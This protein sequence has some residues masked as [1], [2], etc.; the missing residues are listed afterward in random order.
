MEPIEQSKPTGPSISEVL[1]KSN[2]SLNTPVVLPEN[3]Q[4]VAIKDRT[5]GSVPVVVNP[6]VLLKDVQAAMMESLI[7]GRLAGGPI[8]TITNSINDATANTILELRPNADP[9]SKDPTEQLVAQQEAA[10]Y[11]AEKQS[12]VNHWMGST[13]P[14]AVGLKKLMAYNDPEMYPFSGQVNPVD[15]L[16]NSKVYRGYWDT[17]VQE[18]GSWF[19][20]GFQ[21]Y[22]SQELD[23]LEAALG[24][25]QANWSPT[26]AGEL[27]KGFLEENPRLNSWLNARGVNLHE[28]AD[29]AQN[30]LGWTYNVNRAILE[31]ANTDTMVAYYKSNGFLSQLYDSLAEQVTRNPNFAVDAGIAAATFAIPGG[32]EVAATALGLPK[33]ASALGGVTRLVG[34]PMTGPVEGMIYSGLRSTIPSIASNALASTAARGAA[35]VADGMILGAAGEY[36]NQKALA[37]FNGLVL[38]NSLDKQDTDWE[39]ITSV[40]FNAGITQLGFYGAMRT[41]GALTGELGQT[42]RAPYGKRYLTWNQIAMGATDSFAR[43]SSGGTVFGSELGQGRGIPVIGNLLDRYLSKFDDRSPVG[44]IIG[45]EDPKGFTGLTPSVT[46]AA[47]FKMEQALKVEANLKEL[48][49]PLYK[50]DPY[51]VDPAVH[52]ATGLTWD[53]INSTVDHLKETYKKDPG[54][55]T[56]DRL[57]AFNNAI[58]VVIQNRQMAKFGID[59]PSIDIKLRDMG[60]PESLDANGILVRDAVIAHE[61]SK[62]K[63]DK[64]VKYIETMIQSPVGQPL[65]KNVVK[66]LM[67][68]K[69][70]VVI[71]PEESTDNWISMEAGA[72]F[73]MEHTVSELILKDNSITA[74]ARNPHT[75]DGS[76]ILSPSDFSEEINKRLVKIQADLE[77]NKSNQIKE[78]V[79]FAHTSMN[80]IDRNWA[81]GVDSA[82]SVLDT[83]DVSILKNNPESLVSSIQTL[84]DTVD[85]ILKVNAK[86][87]AA[88]ITD[89][90][91]AATLLKKFK[92]LLAETIS[93][94]R[95]VL[96]PEVVSAADALLKDLNKNSSTYSAGGVKKSVKRITKGPANRKF[97]SLDTTGWG[98]VVVD[99]DPALGLESAVTGIE[100]L[101]TGGPQDR[102]S[103]VVDRLKNDQQLNGFY[104]LW[105]LN[106]QGGPPRGTYVNLD[107][108]HLSGSKEGDPVNLGEALSPYAS[109]L[110]RGDVWIYRSQN[111]D[112]QLLRKVD[113]KNTAVS[114][115]NRINAEGYYQLNETGLQ[116]NPLPGSITNLKNIPVSRMSANYGSSPLL[117][118]HWANVAWSNSDPVTLKNVV[119]IFGFENEEVDI[120]AAI[121]KLAGMDPTKM[122]PGLRIAES[123]PG[124]SG[125]TE[126][127]G[128][129]VEQ[130]NKGV[131]AVIRANE[132]STLNSW[133]HEIGHYLETVYIN[134]RSPDSYKAALGLSPDDYGDLMEWLGAKKKADGSWS[135]GIAQREKFAKGWVQYIQTLMSGTAKAPKPYLQELFNKLGAH[136]SLL[137]DETHSVELSESAARVYS[138]LADKLSLDEATMAVIPD[139]AKPTAVEAIVSPELKKVVIQDQIESSILSTKENEV[140]TQVSEAAQ[141]AP[142]VKKARL[143]QV[144]PKKSVEPGTVLP[145]KPVIPKADL[146]LEET[147]FDIKPATIDDNTPV[148]ILTEGDVT[149]PQVKPLDVSTKKF[150]ES[151]AA[152]YDKELRKAARGIAKRS[153]NKADSDDLVSDA[154][155][156]LMTEQHDPSFVANPELLKNKLVLHMQNRAIDSVRKGYGHDPTH[157]DYVNQLMVSADDITATLAAKHGLDKDFLFDSLSSKTVK[158]LAA[159]AEDLK[160]KVKR[161][162]KGA[163]VVPLTKEN[164]DVPDKTVALQS[165]DDAAALYRE[166][167][168]L[169]KQ[170]EPALYD[171]TKASI[172][173]GLNTNKFSLKAVWKEVFPDEPYNV[174]KASKLRS[175]VQKYAEELWGKDGNE[176]TS[177][178]QAK[179]PLQEAHS[180]LNTAK[181]RVRQALF[182]YRSQKVGATEETLRTL[183]NNL[184]SAWG[185]YLQAKDYLRSLKGHEVFS[186]SDLEFLNNLLNN[187]AVPYSSD[188]T[189]KL[190]PNVLNGVV[191]N[192][193]PL[194][195]TFL[196]NVEPLK[197]LFDLS[198][199]D[200][201]KWEAMLQARMKSQLGI[202]TTDNNVFSALVEHTPGLKFLASKFRKF[203]GSQTQ[204][205]AIADSVLVPMQYLAKVLNPQVDLRNV[206]LKAGYY[207]PSLDEARGTARAILAA[208]GLSDPEFISGFSRLGP[209]KQQYTQELAWSYVTRRTELPNDLPKEIESHVKKLWGI[210]DFYNRHKLN[211]LVRQHNLVDVDIDTKSRNYGTPHKASPL[212]YADRNG[213]AQAIKNHW[214]KTISASPEF[215]MGIL[216]AM[217]WIKVNRSSAAGEILDYEVPPTSPLHAKLGP[218]GKIPNDF[219]KYVDD[220]GSLLVPKELVDRYRMALEQVTP[221]YTDA[222]RT[223]HNVT[224]IERDATIASR[225][226]LGLTDPMTKDISGSIGSVYNYTQDH[227]LE[228]IFDHDA[229]S[230]DPELSPYFSKSIVHLL[231]QDSSSSL[232]ELHLNDLLSRSLGANLTVEDLLQVISQNIQRNHPGMSNLEFS[233]FT[234][235]LDRIK[236]IIRAEL[237]RLQASPDDVSGPLNFIS[238]NRRSIL[239]SLSGIPTSLNTFV[240]DLPRLVLKTATSR[241]IFT[242][243]VPTIWESLKVLVNRDK[244]LARMAAMDAAHWIHA[245]HNDTSSPR[246]GD[247]EHLGEDATV[248]LKMPVVNSESHLGFLLRKLLNWK[249]ERFLPG[250]S[251]NN[252]KMGTLLHTASTIPGLL[253]RT[254]N[255]ATSAIH[256]YHYGNLIV[257]N[258]D[259]LLK[260]VDMLPDHTELSRPKFNALAVSLGLKPDEVIEMSS[261]GLLNKPHLL[262]IA[263]GIKETGL[264]AGI[265]DVPKL[266]NWALQLKAPEESALATDAIGRM[267]GFIQTTLRNTNRE[268]TLLDLRVSTN[269]V[270]KI[271][272]AYTQFVYS[273]SV[274]SWGQLSRRGTVAASRFLFGQ[275]AAEAAIMFTLDSILTPDNP[276]DK[277]EEMMT[278]PMA[279]TAFALSRAPLWG[280]YSWVVRNALVLGFL[281]RNQIFGIEPPNQKWESLQFPTFLNSPIGTQVDNTGKLLAKTPGLVGKFLSGQPMTP[282]EKSWAIRMLPG[283]RNLALWGLSSGL[284]MN[285]SERNQSRNERRIKAGMNPVVPLVTPG[286][287]P[288]VQPQ[289]SPPEPEPEPKPQDTSL[290]NRIQNKPALG[291]GLLRSLR[292]PG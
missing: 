40:G 224:P 122:A 133:A 247:F 229:I 7:D 238:K 82:T 97:K 103:A 265:P 119:N 292:N 281:L 19:S 51:L 150:V 136:I 28:W 13:D 62:V 155:E 284:F 63:V 99:A 226:L 235:G 159:I 64:T 112:I 240:G 23:Q 253:V 282:S 168:T 95:M 49:D 90:A 33:V 242:K 149:D 56:M 41:F 73:K 46:S 167:I 60:L 241:D 14:N 75:S 283:S 213:F 198:D 280:T 154:Y 93:S 239:T 171:W 152:T 176:V 202:R 214:M 183:R 16:Q 290:V 230:R 254:A 22:A 139:I 186:V 160:T 278:N 24:E 59:A 76:V 127:A 120:A 228:R 96:K 196:N 157:E 134:P 117:T 244:R 187:V 166:L 31:A 275:F 272:N 80:E 111:N 153:G 86:L 145:D 47:N 8:Q 118:D 142:V 88:Q 208:S 291:T 125:I 137:K 79:N 199:I 289:V 100:H 276:G 144:K 285:E 274:Q 190:L 106:S 277:L 218:D 205:G 173:H 35:L 67:G 32:G 94:K 17:F 61:V 146:A 258:M 66:D 128:I 83:T 234:K 175:K 50:V 255:D 6:S 207:M 195:L 107:N 42:L 257:N 210:L 194:G 221:D 18:K 53:D 249:N 188:Y 259:S 129:L 246:M 55:R 74:D 45:W 256:A 161:E 70:R 104:G 269:P 101:Y 81:S 135:Y 211:M 114:L 227:L 172:E 212:A 1:S 243:F 179:D 170:E 126:S 264:T 222:Y 165:T 130:W 178:S 279:L 217:G 184:K 102:I 12:L 268:P 37:R 109:L 158:E 287:K 252:N 215:N 220:S 89:A 29:Q 225:R 267:A 21:T 26:V 200:R 5:T 43:T 236:N 250:L 113:N 251:G 108:V 115:G 84:K 68:D 189:F 30:S 216:D 110:A 261:N 121:M 54:P 39:T 169:V 20:N 201:A 219:L 245:I 288:Q 164:A 151:F 36:Q 262:M 182:T 48:I 237:H 11:W 87:T 140:A 2:E 57:Q 223:L 78:L 185:S 3:P 71:V 116:W 181:G 231:A 148:S 174:K 163:K 38:P 138:K 273:N 69:Q 248:P 77:L 91:H 266:L 286:D 143:V 180:K 203:I 206:E 147:P 177:F 10:R 58:A 15:W 123:L 4:V 192:K 162:A 98:E 141:E 124:F 131:R 132:A 72:D 156:Y 197:R 270:M 34:G 52:E 263:R 204:Y 25:P 9:E 209:A 191:V 65:I 105:S 193:V 44:V 271:L 92:P 233:E 27:T 232:F 85:N 260:L